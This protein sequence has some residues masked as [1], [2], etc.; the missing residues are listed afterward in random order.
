MGAMKMVFPNSVER[1]GVA[2]IAITFALAALANAQQVPPRPAKALHV[3]AEAT[4]AGT[5]VTPATKPTQSSQL[6]ST[7]QNPRPRESHQ[8]RLDASFVAILSVVSLAPAIL[9]M[10]TSFTR[11]IIVL[12]LL[13]QALGAQQLPPNQVLVG[14]RCS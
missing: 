7:I 1:G 9:L 5:P 13:R 2:V 4:S 3:V 14:F 8:H 12:S 10:L 6:A 11:M